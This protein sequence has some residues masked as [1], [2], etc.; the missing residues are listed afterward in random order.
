MPDQPFDATHPTGTILFRATRGGILQGIQFA[1]NLFDVFDNAEQIAEAILLT[2]DVSHLEAVME[3]RAELIAGG[4]PPTAA[5][6][7]PDDLYEA[8]EALRRHAAM[9]Q[10]GHP[11]SGA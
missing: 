1:D 6:P 2:A 5:V 9:L 8:K 10:Q 11:H 7:T 4:T 3:V